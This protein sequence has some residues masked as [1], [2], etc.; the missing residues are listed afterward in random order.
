MGILCYY[1]CMK[2]QLADFGESNTKD[3]A[4]VIVKISIERLLIILASKVWPTNIIEQIA[5]EANG[6]LL[7]HE[8]NMI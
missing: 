1:I 7:K 6:P 5:K 8:V 4:D 3:G 2:V